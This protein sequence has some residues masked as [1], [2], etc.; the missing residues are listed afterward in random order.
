MKLNLSLHLIVLTV[1]IFVPFL[2]STLG[3]TRLSSTTPSTDLDVR[4]PKDGAEQVIFNYFQALREKR[5]DDAYSLIALDFKG[6]VPASIA[7]NI[8]PGTTAQQGFINLYG[9][10]NYDNSVNNIVSVERIFK[11]IDGQAF[12]SPTEAIY[13]GS[14]SNPISS[15][16]PN[17]YR[18]YA[19][20][21]GYKQ[22]GKYSQFAVKEFPHRSGKW[23]IAEIVSVCKQ[24]P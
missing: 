19:V 5:Y 24:C 6:R 10:W 9:F 8:T 1:V 21:T 20:D 3:C 13:I 23:L 17:T 4:I 18:V 15:P 22:N 11:P 12:S 7:N 14:R 16:Y 2:G